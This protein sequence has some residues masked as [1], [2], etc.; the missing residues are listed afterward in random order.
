M[1]S[2][3]IYGNDMKKITVITVTLNSESTLKKTLDS[4]S[5]QSYKGIE[6]IIV[7]GGSKDSTELIIKKHKSDLIKYYVYPGSSIYEAMNYGIKMA[8]NEFIAFLNS[9]DYY[10][11]SDSISMAMKHF[12]SSNELDAVFSDVEFF[13]ASNESKVVRGY[14]CK[15]FLPILL[16]DGIMPPHPGIVIK[17]SLYQELGG[18]SNSYKIA[19]DFDF[20]LRLF[21]KH[22]IK[23]LVTGKIFVRMRIGGISTRGLTSKFQITMEIYRSLKS[24]GVNPNLSFL[25]KRYINK[26]LQMKI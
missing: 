10:L 8:S 17:K 26:L 4:V 22:R 21:K 15:N 19:S 25:Y 12:E 5:A 1:L 3:Y 20:L 23:Y 11:D 24:N 9:D 16:N 6:H 13:S 7:D 18:F 2:R 14:N